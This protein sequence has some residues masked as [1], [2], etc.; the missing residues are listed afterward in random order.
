MSVVKSMA[1][2][3]LSGSSVTVCTVALVPE[4]WVHR[5]HAVKAL[6][7]ASGRFAPCMWHSSSEL[8]VVLWIEHQLAA[9]AGLVLL[10]FALAALDFAWGQ[11]FL[12]CPR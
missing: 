12:V 6:P 8:D 3:M 4:Q 10:F 5:V 1:I 7:D 2:F 11:S 9:P